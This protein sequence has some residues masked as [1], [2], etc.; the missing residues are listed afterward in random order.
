MILPKSADSIAQTVIGC[1]I[2]IGLR[3]LRLNKQN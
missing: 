1:A 3:G 2:A